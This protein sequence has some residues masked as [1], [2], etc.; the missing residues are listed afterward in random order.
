MDL[1]PVDAAHVERDLGQC[2]RGL[3]RE[4][5]SDPRGADPIADLERP[6]TNT[7]VESRAADRL[8]LVRSEDPVDEVLTEVEAAA[9][10]AEELGFLLDRRRLVG[11]PRHPGAKVVEARVERVFQERRVT[12]FPAADRQ[13]VGAD[14]VRRRGMVDGA[15]LNVAQPTAR[16]GRRAGWPARRRSRRDRAARPPR[17]WPPGSGAGPRGS[18][19]RARAPASVRRRSRA[20]GTRAT[21]RCPRAGTLRHRGTG[22]RARSSRGVGARNRRPPSRARTPCHRAHSCRQGGGSTSGSTPRRPRPRSAAA[23]RPAPEEL[24]FVQRVYTIIRAHGC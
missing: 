20:R 15:Q 21:S 3:P 11:R 24:D 17:G 14:E 12:R 5:L 10:H 7:R 4:A 6:V 9:E 1:D 16:R 13:A 19:R 8:A 23:R 22:A 18:P 2:R